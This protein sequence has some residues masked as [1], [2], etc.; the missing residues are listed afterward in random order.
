VESEGSSA[1]DRLFPAEPNP[2]AERAQIR[3][4]LAR[5]AAVRISVYDVTGREVR[6]LVDGLS[7]AGIHSV[8]WDGAND[9][10]RRVGSGIYWMQMRTG[11]FVSNRKLLTIR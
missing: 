2:F 11:G 8:V 10:G 9:E 7:D 6:R 5:R 4:S 3:F 1:V